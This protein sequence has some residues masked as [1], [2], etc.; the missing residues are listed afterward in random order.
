MAF[1]AFL[2]LAAFSAAGPANA[3]PFAGGNEVT[4]FNFD[5]TPNGSTPPTTYPGVDSYPQ[6]DIYAIGG[7]PDAGGSPTGTVTVQ[8][9]STMSHAAVMTTAQSGTGSLYMDTQFHTSGNK[10][11]TSFD[12]AILAMPLTGLSQAT[13]TAPNGQG[14]IIQAFGN[15]PGGVDKVFRFVATPEGNFGLRNNTDGDLIIV[16]SYVLGQTYHVQIDT[17]FATQTL[18]AYI[19][20]TLVAD[21][22]A[23]VTPGASDFEEYFIFQ[24]GVD[25]AENKAAIDNIVTYDNIRAFGAV[26]EPI[27]LALFGAGLGGI[28]AVRRRKAK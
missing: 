21:D 13:G 6:H 1:G 17:D 4:N 12:L 2:A 27:T 22:F 7:F 11:S 28:A 26:P 5:S 25:N 24:N 16:G 20:D 10:V 23:I 19:D 14:F 8:D 3:V 15:T 18:D 9:V